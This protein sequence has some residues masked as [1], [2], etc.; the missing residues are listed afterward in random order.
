MVLRGGIQL[1]WMKSGGSLNNK[2]PHSRSDLNV[3]RKML[4]RGPASDRGWPGHHGQAAETRPILQEQ[5]G[6]S[7]GN[8]YLSGQ[9]EEKRIE[10]D[11]IQNEKATSLTISSTINGRH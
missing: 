5:R 10:A 8:L 7:Q 9:D 6:R 3:R 11:D 1:E 2:P 4:W